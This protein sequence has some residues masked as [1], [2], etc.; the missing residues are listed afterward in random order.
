MSD[1]YENIWTSNTLRDLEGEAIQEHTPVVASIGFDWFSSDH[2]MHYSGPGKSWWGSDI[3]M[4]KIGEGSIII[5][6]LRLVNN[7]GKDPAADKVFFN[8]LDFATEL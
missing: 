3:A 7:L 5:S 8:M 2:K 6:Q 1:F 4:L